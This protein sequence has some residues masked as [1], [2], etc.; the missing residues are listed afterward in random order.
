M[1]IERRII[2]LGRGDDDEEEEDDPDYNSEIEEDDE[3]DEEEE[4]ED[5]FNFK[6][7]ISELE[8]QRSMQDNQVGPIDKNELKFLN[9]W[10]LKNEFRL[11][12]FILMKI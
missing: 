9:D 1:V 2:C 3:D 10:S 4:E 5:P 11:K 6:D 8:R 7:R 12:N